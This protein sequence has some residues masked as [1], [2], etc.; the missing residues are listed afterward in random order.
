[1][2]LPLIP[3]DKKALDKQI[4]DL[5]KLDTKTLKTLKKDIQS[6]ISNI[7]TRL[8]STNDF[9]SQLI[10][11][12]NKN[13]RDWQ[14]EDDYRNSEQVLK[15]IY[16]DSAARDMEKYPSPGEFEID[17][18]TEITNVIKC[19]LVQGKFP[20]SDP[21]VRSGNQIIRFS[22]FAEPGPPT[23]VHETTIPSG[24]Y[25]GDDLALEISTQVNIAQF[26]GDIQAGLKY[27]NY[28]DGLVYEDSSFTILTSYNI[29]VTFIKNRQ[30]FLF[31]VYDN[32][33]EPTSV[34]LLR[35]Y[36]KGVKPNNRPYHEQIDDLWD[37][38]GF[39][40]LDAEK[41]GTS[42]ILNRNEYFYVDSNTAYDSFGGGQNLLDTRYNYA[43]RSNLAS[44][45]NNPVC[46]ILSIDVF[47]DNDI[48]CVEQGPYK[49][50]FSGSMFG[51]VFL[52]DAAA[53][54]ELTVELNSMSFPA[55]K[56]YVE[57]INRVK[58]LHIKLYRPDGTLFTFGGRDWKITL[59]V[60][61]KQT[62]PPRP[63]FP[64]GG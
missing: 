13:L 39:N 51:M 8:K 25:K 31:Q 3:N 30:M 63:V 5:S 50:P 40:R 36:I 42:I 49:K 59:A 56:N 10:A 32:T 52:K 6:R 34:Q 17:I 28:E 33:G 4:G 60:T 2:S 48:V 27:V 53:N 29:K 18:Q 20:L 14:K 15:W 55:R 38:L 61:T 9:E 7:D 43:L 16:I 1:M 26:A 24:N 19:D 21:S 23:D 54:S 58:K 37:V 44:E 11:I 46:A 62:Q 35:L 57:G 45:L 64:R 12:E 47:D 22:V 41:E